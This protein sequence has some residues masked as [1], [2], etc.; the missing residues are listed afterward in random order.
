VP[1][2]QSVLRERIALVASYV[3]PASLIGGRLFVPVPFDPDREWAPKPQHHIHG[4]VAGCKVRGVITTV[5]GRLY[6]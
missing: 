2:S 3:T 1:C 4:T 5:D 6:P